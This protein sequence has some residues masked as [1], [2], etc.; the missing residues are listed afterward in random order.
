[1]N[2]ETIQKVIAVKA[3][4]EASLLK[5]ANVVGVGVGFRQKQDKLTDEIVLIVNVSR[6]LPADQIAPEDIIP[7]EIEGVPVDVCQIGEIRAL[8]K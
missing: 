4:H 2:D 6:K 1:M 7:R 5:K 8:N 3:R